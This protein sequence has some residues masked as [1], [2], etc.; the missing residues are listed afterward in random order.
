MTRAL[1]SCAPELK[2]ADLATVL[3]LGDKLLKG[4]EKEIIPRFATLFTLHL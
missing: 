3:A 4:T 1:A 2:T